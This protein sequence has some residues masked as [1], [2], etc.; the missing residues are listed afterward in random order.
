MWA[1]VIQFWLKWVGSFCFTQMN[2][3]MMMQCNNNEPRRPNSFYFVV[4]TWPT[5]ITPL[6]LP[7]IFNWSHYFEVETK[8]LL[9]GKTQIEKVP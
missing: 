6:A 3:V 8:S 1:L 7:D 4:V 9:V 2:E 5:H